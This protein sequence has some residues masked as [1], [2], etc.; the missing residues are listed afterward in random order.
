MGDEHLIP[1][2]SELVIPDDHIDKDYQRR[3]DLMVEKV[4]NLPFVYENVSKGYV[5]SFEL[6]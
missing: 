4:L 1:T 3:F 2:P 5:G 6:K